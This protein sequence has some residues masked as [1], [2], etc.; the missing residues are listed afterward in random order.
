MRKLSIS[1]MLLIAIFCAKDL[2]AQQENDLSKFYGKVSNY[3]SVLNDKNNMDNIVFYRIGWNG[4]TPKTIGIQFGN[5]GY[6]DQKLK[7]AIKD[8]TSKKFVV[9][10]KVHNSFFGTEILKASSK[11]IVWSGLVDNIDDSFSLHVWVGDGD[12]I[13]KEPVSIK[14]KK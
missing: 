5:F 8:V 10:D 4:K 9:L 1:A 6:A 7:F 12:E 3:I 2:C 13:D 11:G 14:D